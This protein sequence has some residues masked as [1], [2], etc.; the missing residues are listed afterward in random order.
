MV[1][2]MTLNKHV[3]DQKNE[4]KW[5]IK[6]LK[7]HNKSACKGKGI[8]DK[9]EVPLKVEIDNFPCVSTGI[10]LG[11]KQH[12][13]YCWLLTRVKAAVLILVFP[14]RADTWL[15]FKNQARFITNWSN[16]EK[17][18]PGRQKHILRQADLLTS[19]NSHL[20]WPGRTKP[21]PVSVR[22]LV[23]MC[24]LWMVAWFGMWM[25]D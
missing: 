22:F 20:F 24:S 18:G 21:L 14:R 25:Q 15:G 12:N 23:L 2:A 5:S 3:V 10:M 9:I 1:R 8:K 19:F 4:L 11:P 13:G 7:E 6:W 16:Q 17:Q